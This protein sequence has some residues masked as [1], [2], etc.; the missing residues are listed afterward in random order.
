MTGLSEVPST[1]IRAI[2]SIEKAMRQ[3]HP[4]AIPMLKEQLLA[5]EEPLDTAQRAL[6]AHDG[7]GW[8]GYTRQVLTHACTLILDSIRIFGTGGDATQAFMSVLTAMRKHCQAQEALFELCDGFPQINRYFLEGEPAPEVAAHH[9]GKP[10]LFHSLQNQA[11][12]AR[13]GYS[14]FVPESY[15]PDHPMPLVVALHGG[16]GHGRDFLW[17]WL[18]EARSRGFILMAPS[19]LGRT[20]SIADIS[21]DAWQ[22]IRHVDEVCSRYTI[23]SDR[24]LV[25]GM[26]DGGTFALGFGFQKDCPIKAIAPVS[27]VLV[28]V[29]LDLAGHRRVYWVHGAQDWM[30]PVGRAV[31]AC[32]ELSSAGADVRLKVVPDLSHAYPREENDAILRW[33]EPSLAP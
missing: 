3:L 21:M 29:D 31:K 5:H 2:T 10:K 8:D 24:M 9:P 18:R 16:Y 13:G 7:P 23:D 27:C 14:L 30:F 15:S 12:Y 19:S 33:F 11:P 20:W 32:K 4:L 6:L 26:S 1:F 25:T 28:P 17:T 22:L